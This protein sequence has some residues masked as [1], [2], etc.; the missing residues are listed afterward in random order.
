MDK[1]TLGKYKKALIEASQSNEWDR[2]RACILS[3]R[4]R[5]YDCRFEFT[6]EQIVRLRDLD[7][8]I[9]EKEKRVFSQLV[10]LVRY[11]DQTQPSYAFDDLEFD[12]E[13]DLFSDEL[14]DNDENLVG[15]PFVT[16]EPVHLSNLAITGSLIYEQ[17]ELD[18][19]ALYQLWYQEHYWNRFDQINT[20]FTDY[21]YCISFQEL[22]CYSN[23][24][25]EDLLKTDTIWY[26]IKIEMQ[27]FI[28]FPANA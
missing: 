8:Q 18:A 3:E 20:A 14:F 27:N 4:K 15:N 24:A 22:L 1:E 17:P 21:E 7:R 28:E 26:S 11:L 19:E 2:E 25:F 10:H 5:Y 9:R 16:Y 13:I 12:C 23:C 6:N